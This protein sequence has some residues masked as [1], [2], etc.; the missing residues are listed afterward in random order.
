MKSDLWARMRRWWH[1]H[2]FGLSPAAADDLADGIDL[3]DRDIERGTRSMVDSPLADEV[4]GASGGPAISP[5]PVD[6]VLGAGMFYTKPEL[7]RII[8]ECKAE[9]GAKP[10]AAC[11]G[12]RTVADLDDLDRRFLAGGPVADAV[13]R[14]LARDLKRSALEIETLRA[15]EA[16][17]RLAAV[18]KEKDRDFMASFLWHVAQ[19]IQHHLAHETARRRMFEQVDMTAG[20]TKG[21][22][23]RTRDAAP[24][25]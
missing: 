14:G 22:D 25:T 8:K 19:R 21:G 6:P 13:V 11:P 4:N 2:I 7:L 9:R 16:L 24:T 23:E 18:W 10:K 5:V 20:P 17:E 12:L 3:G 1:I 15:V